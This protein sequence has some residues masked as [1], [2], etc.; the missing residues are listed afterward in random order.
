MVDE[1]CLQLTQCL[2]NGCAGPGDDD[3]RNPT[4]IMHD[5]LSMS[6]LTLM[7]PA[8]KTSCCMSFAWLS[9]DLSMVVLLGSNLVETAAMPPSAWWMKLAC[10]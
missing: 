4:R 3:N 10:S 7:G 5:E 9:F 6:F 8:T 2:Q 1:A